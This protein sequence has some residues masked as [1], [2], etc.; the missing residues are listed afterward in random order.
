ME[1]QVVGQGGGVE[2]V[3][4]GQQ[5]LGAAVGFS[6]APGRAALQGREVRDEA[7]ATVG[8]EA[9][10]LLALPGG[11][12]A[13]LLA[14]GRRRRLVQ[15]VDGERV[16]EVGVGVAGLRVRQR[17]VG[18]GEVG[19]LEIGGSRVGERRGRAVQVLA[20]RREVREPRVAVAA[21]IVAV[22]EGRRGG[23][24]ERRRSVRGEGC[25]VPGGTGKA[26]PL[27]TGGFSFF[28]FF[29]SQCSLRRK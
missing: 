13:L 19:G 24:E 22:L 4:V 29:F 18:R 21:A 3:A 1:A 17:L 12:S 25:R 7:G 27:L 20:D 11:P 5:Q 9:G 10:R 2:A 6:T 16:P 14:G 26:V 8:G 28:F 23:G 15:G